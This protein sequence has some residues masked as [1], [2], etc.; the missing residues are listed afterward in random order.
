MIIASAEYH[1]VSEVNAKGLMGDMRLLIEKAISVNADIILL[2]AYIGCLYDMIRNGRGSVK[3]LFER[4]GGFFL[5]D[6]QRLSAEY[7]IHICPGSFWEQENGRVYHASCIL[8]NGE[9]IVKQRQLY[10]A[11]WERDFGLERGTKTSL[12]DIGGRKIGIIVST[13]VF[14]PQVSRELALKGADVVL[15]PAAFIGERNDAVQLSGMWQQT[16][17]NLF[18][19]VESGYNGP[20]GELLLWGQSNI[21]APLEMTEHEDGFLVHNQENKP[22]IFCSL[23]NEKR[24]AAVA[25]FDVLGPLN[26]EL[27][28]SMRLLSGDH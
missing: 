4:P 17:Q 14:Y 3:E 27:Y 13:D 8:Y 6:M 22:F 15:C 1:S 7:K 28:H 25:K 2:P 16:Q 23:D 24:K 21:Y 10:L 9:I 18:F 11:R 19:A 12:A 5:E 20:I 26:K